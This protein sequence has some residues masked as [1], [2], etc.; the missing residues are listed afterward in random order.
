MHMSHVWL[1]G[2]CFGRS[3]AYITG[4]RGAC[5]HPY[6]GGGAIT[7]TWVGVQSPLQWCVC[8]WGGGGGGGVL[9][10]RLTQL[11]SIGGLELILR[12][13]VS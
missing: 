6:V 9:W 11:T 8:V 2:T 4:Y 12:L 10:T 3:L 1:F 7:L 5:N 13:E